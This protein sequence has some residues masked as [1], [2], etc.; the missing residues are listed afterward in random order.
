MEMGF[1]VVNVSVMFQTTT[2]GY[3]VG[4]LKLF[5]ST[6]TGTLMILVVKYH[7]TFSAQLAP[8]NYLEYKFQMLSNAAVMEQVP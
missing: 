5:G 8:L 7:L 3:R 1:M 2:Q 4:V 6:F